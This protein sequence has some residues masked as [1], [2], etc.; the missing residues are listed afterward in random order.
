MPTMTA[1]ITVVRRPASIAV[2]ALLLALGAC[3]LKVTNPGPL[4]DADLNTAGA[5]PA[6]V[7]GMGGDLSFAL[8]N[9]LTRGSLGSFELIHSGNFASERQ[10]AA[11]V[12]RPED[13]NVDW[14][15]MHTAR[16]VAEAGLERMK[17]VLGADF[18]SNT[19]TPFA[20]SVQPRFS[21]V[22]SGR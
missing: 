11:G 15:R 18:E 12:I 9:Y 19:N 5:I 21:F 3:D 6:L 16:Y 4:L 20:R 7:N 22:M 2:S 17:T 14:A 8:G 10:Y 1:F 13:V